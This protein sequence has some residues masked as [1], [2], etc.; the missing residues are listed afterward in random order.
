MIIA[1][2]LLTNRTAE[3]SSIAVPL[4]K[5]SG[6]SSLQILSAHNTQMSRMHPMRLALGVVL[7]LG[8]F[9]A[10]THATADVLEEVLVSGK[11]DPRLSSLLTGTEVRSIAEDEQITA[12]LTPA[13]LAEAIPGVSMNGQGGLF[14]SYSLR[15]FSRW[16][17]RT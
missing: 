11:A 7:N 14:Q 8:A 13:S 17:I 10:S 15:G 16:R 9:S 2:K 4:H 6:G 3:A 12:S 1:T 5:A